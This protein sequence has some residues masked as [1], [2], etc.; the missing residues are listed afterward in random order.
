MAK[1]AWEIE[2]EMRKNAV[3]LDRRTHAS[4]WLEHVKTFYEA[5]QVIRFWRNRVPGSGAPDSLYVGMVQSMA[6]RGYDV[7]AAEELLP[8]GLALAE[9][10]EVAE[11]RVLTAILMEQIFKAPLDTQCAYHSFY[12][13]CDWES[14]IAA[15]SPN[16]DKS[17]HLIMQ[18]DFD[19]RIYH[20]WLGQ[21]AGGSF[22]TVLEGYDGEQIGHVYGEINAYITQPETM[23]DDV[24]YEL[25][26]LDAFEK[27]RRAITSR[28]VA[29]EWVRQIPY[30]Y[31]AEWVALNN[32][33]NGI[34]PPESGSFRNPYSDWIGAQMRGMVCG[35]LSPGCPFEAVRLGYID[36]VISHSAN[37][38]YGEMYA[39]ALTSLAFVENDVHEMVEAGVD[40]L[41]Q[42]S[43]YSAVVKE[44]L[45]V[46]RQ[47]IYAKDAWKT[48]DERFREY[49]WIHAYPNIAASLCALWYG[50][51]DMTLSFSLLAQAGLDVDCNAG[52]VGTI[53]GIMNGV[54]TAWSEPLGDLLETYLPGKEKLS[55]R[56]LAKRTAILARKV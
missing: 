16:V 54:P 4:Q 39:A 27:K 5:D 49:H 28:E 7:S 42:E 20:G 29:L 24:I 33:K 50:D 34:F 18:K 9:Q 32:I 2:R 31:S 56:Q 13:P 21:L 19:E 15:M 52:L 51:G 38:L 55:I 8:I 26:F 45:E 48:L 12:H 36:G 37:G 11:L 17:I 40:Y 41:P 25:V 10:G 46:L 47:N 23:N 30:G 6:N 44:V 43:E 1:K 14:I 35:M 22:G 3:P 53:L